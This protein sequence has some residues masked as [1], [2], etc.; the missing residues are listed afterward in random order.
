MK[1]DVT[2]NNVVYLEI[3]NWTYYIDNSTGEQI[4]EKWETKK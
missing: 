3:D 1:I 4:M 2:S